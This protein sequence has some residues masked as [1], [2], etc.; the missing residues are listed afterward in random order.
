M[1]SMMVYAAFEQDGTLARW[2]DFLGYSACGIF[3]TPERG[4]LKYAKR[5][6]AAQSQRQ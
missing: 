1:L 6:R 5:Q 2:T 4:N 3:G